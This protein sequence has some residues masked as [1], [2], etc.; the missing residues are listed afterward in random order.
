MAIAS[1][2][3]SESIGLDTERMVRTA[4][5]AK[6][7]LLSKVES[8]TN[9][10]RGYLLADVESQKK[11]N[12][13]AFQRA[14]LGKRI[15][16][17]TFAS[18]EGPKP[19]AVVETFFVDGAGTLHDLPSPLAGHRLLVTGM[20]SAIKSYTD[21]N[22]GWYEQQGPET[23]IKNFME[24]EIAMEKNA[25]GPPISI[26][27]LDAGGAHWIEAGACPAIRN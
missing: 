4:V 6:G 15:L 3:K 5:A 20:T 9:A 17:V 26:L 13:A 2:G 27:K 16:D 19:E 22:T 23:A 7:P 25:V 24:L 18:I 21:R 11:S 12:M 10:A 14:Y 1:G 8:F